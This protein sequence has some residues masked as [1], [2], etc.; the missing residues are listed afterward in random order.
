[1]SKPAIF[2]EWTNS[3]LEKISIQIPQRGHFA[4][5]PVL[6]IHDDGVSGAE[7]PM[8]FDRGTQ[9]WLLKQIVYLSVRG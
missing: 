8:L 2:S 3:E 1:M 6:V 5:Q 9:N 4:G 7:A